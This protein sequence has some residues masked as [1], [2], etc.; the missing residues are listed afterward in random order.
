M[1]KKG[2]MC[3]CQSQ[4]IGSFWRKQRRY[5]R[6]DRR[7]EYRQAALVYLAGINYIA[8]TYNSSSQLE[9]LWSLVHLRK[10]LH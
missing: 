4:V 3:K 2:D 1:W 10:D 7:I 6:V 8:L 9:C 5:K